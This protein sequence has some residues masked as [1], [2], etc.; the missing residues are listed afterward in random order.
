MIAL[1]WLGVQTARIQREEAL[2]RQ[3]ARYRRYAQQVQ[4][5]VL[6]GVW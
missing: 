6:P 5:R 3:D 4:W 1:V 2:L